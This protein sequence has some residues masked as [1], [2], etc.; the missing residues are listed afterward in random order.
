MGDVAC[1]ARANMTVSFYNPQTADL[2]E[3]FDLMNGQGFTLR[4][5]GARADDGGHTVIVRG[6]LR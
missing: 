3:E 6:V 4:P 2:I 1:S 5:M